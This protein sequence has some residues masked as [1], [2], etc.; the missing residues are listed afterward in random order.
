[1]SVV[2]FE[3]SIKTDSPPPSLFAV[4]YLQHYLPFFKDLFP[5][6]MGR[7]A[8]SIQDHID[9]AQKRGYFVQSSSD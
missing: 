1:V 3:S 6:T 4:C 9:L 8:L 5:A 2:R 7:K